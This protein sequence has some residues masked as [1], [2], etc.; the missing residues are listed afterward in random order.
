MVGCAGV[1]LFSEGEPMNTYTPQVV[2]MWQ[3]F[4]KKMTQVDKFGRDAYLGACIVV[5]GKE[6]IHEENV[7]DI[8]L[9]VEQQAHKILMDCDVSSRHAT[10]M[11]RG[12]RRAAILSV[13]ISFSQSVPLDRCV[14]AIAK[15][16]DMPGDFKENLVK[17]YRALAHERAV[18]NSQRAAEKYSFVI[19]RMGDKEPPLD[20]ESHVMSQL[21]RLLGMEAVADCPTLQKIAEIVDE[22]FGE[23]EDE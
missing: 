17:S 8:M 9:S 7:A 16:K 18:K 5:G 6:W 21:K 4:A 3:T 11:I 12:A 20:Y 2:K 22:Y 19:R 23:L 13:P 1:I 14:K 10:S 15:A